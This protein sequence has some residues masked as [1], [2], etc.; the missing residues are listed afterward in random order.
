M[1]L[2]LL[3]SA[4][5]LA[6]VAL[7][8]LA[9][10]LEDYGLTVIVTLFA[11]VIAIGQVKPTAKV[12]SATIMS[13]AL[14]D[15]STRAAVGTHK[16]PIG[17]LIDYIE[18]G[19]YPVMTT[20]L[21][22][23]PHGGLVEMFNDKIKW[24]PFEFYTQN[25]KLLTTT[26]SRLKPMRIPV[27]KNLPNDSTITV[28][29]TAFNAATDVLAVTFH[30]RFGASSGVQ[31]YSKCGKG[32]ATAYTVQTWYADAVTITIP[33]GGRAV[34]ALASFA[35]TPE[36]IV[37]EGGLVSL[38]A[39]GVDWVPTQFT[40]ESVSGITTLA[41]EVHQNGLVLDHPLPS[42]TTVRAA[43]KVWDNQSQLLLL[44]IVWEG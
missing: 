40:T 44:C 1:T 11:S 22:T 16:A 32:T 26:G 38:T 21:N 9:P 13:A 3:V 10:I 33:N 18:I 4:V 37:C 6:S 19:V 36:T 5:A 15:H 14:A 7:V 12:A 43:V 24:D 31:T 25:P 28:Y 35:G 42:N 2:L 8:T 23:T 34:L 39:D 41:G 17:G 29:Y 30:W 27:K 20:A